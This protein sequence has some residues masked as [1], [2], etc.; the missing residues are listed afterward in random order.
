[1]GVGFR[2]LLTAK[3]PQLNAFVMPQAMLARQ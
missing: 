3:R 1:M 2:L